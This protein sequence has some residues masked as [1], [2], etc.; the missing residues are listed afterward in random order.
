[1]LLTFT[2]SILKYGNWN[3]TAVYN[4]VV[5]CTYTIDLN[6]REELQCP[7]LERSHVVALEI[8]IAVHPLTLFL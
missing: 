1:M 2:I 7:F 6:E 4:Y 8:I 5:S 3:V